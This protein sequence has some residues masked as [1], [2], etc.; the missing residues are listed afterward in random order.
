MKRPDKEDDKYWGPIEN[1]GKGTRSSR[2]NHILYE[3]NLER[4]LDYLESTKDFKYSGIPNICFSLTEPDDDREVEFSKQ[5]LSRGFDDSE[6]WSLRDTIAQFIIPRLE[7][8]IE[9]T[10]DVLI[11]DDKLISD[12]NEFLVSMELV[13]KDGDGETLTDSE[14]KQMLEGLKKF[15]KI[16]LS[17]WW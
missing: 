2:F 4:Y 13:V 7:R 14:R 8:Y 3:E 15:D 11:R 6:T 10:G 1:D 5:R 17:L 12:I 16:F 9:I